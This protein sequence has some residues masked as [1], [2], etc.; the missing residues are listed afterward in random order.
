MSKTAL[1]SGI[2]G[3][4]G[5]CLARHLLSM[6][7]VPVN[8]EID[9]AK[10]RP[11]DVPVPAASSRRAYEDLHWKPAHSLKEALSVTL[12]WWRNRGADPDLPGKY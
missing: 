8:V 9:P 5:A 10:F 12:N 2:T 3:Q 4:A 1:I 7:P 6:S 11:M